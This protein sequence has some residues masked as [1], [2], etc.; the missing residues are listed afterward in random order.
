VPIEQSDLRRKA[1]LLIACGALPALLVSP[2]VTGSYHVA[3]KQCARAFVVGLEQAPSDLEL[4]SIINDGQASSLAKAQLVWTERQQGSKRKAA[5]A[6]EVAAS[7]EAASRAAAEAAKKAAQRKAASKEARPKAAEA[8]ADLKAAERLLGAAMPLPFQVGDVARLEP[9][10][11][12][13]RQAGVAKA[14]IASA[15]LRLEEA[16][17][18]AA[19]APKAKAKTKV[20][21]VAK[22]KA[23]ASRS[24][25][26][27]PAAVNPAKAKAVREAERVLGAAM[28][29]PFQVANA[30]RLELALKTARQAGV[31]E[32]LVASAETRLRE[33]RAAFGLGL[34]LGLGLG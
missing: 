29:L 18:A 7:R 11:A 20:Q 16:R 27:K 32:R 26:A 9:A 14:L 19:A 30:T 6:A 24:V 23:G 22:A 3:R 4:I 10:I 17:A 13:A 31:S 5:R 2:H 25:G 12:A 34:G 21:A 28:P 33:V 8:D 1:M 15:E